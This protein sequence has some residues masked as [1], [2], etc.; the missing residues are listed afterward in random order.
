[1][2]STTDPAEEQAAKGKSRKSSQL[3]PKCRQPSWNTCQP[4]GELPVRLVNETP[5]IGKVE[6]FNPDYE[7]PFHYQSPLED[8]E[9]EGGGGNDNDVSPFSLQRLLPQPA[10]E[11]STK[12]DP[13][14]GEEDSPFIYEQLLKRLAEKTTNE[15]SKEAPAGEKSTVEAP[16]ILAPAAAWFWQCHRVRSRPHSPLSPKPPY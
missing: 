8:L 11:K 9:E 5:P 6:R 4:S 3:Q 13:G 2:E 7:R 15:E 12:E 1:M 14:E 10:E 16:P